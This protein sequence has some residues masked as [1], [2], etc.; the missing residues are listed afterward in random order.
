MVIYYGALPNPIQRGHFTPI[1]TAFVLA[2]VRSSVTRTFTGTLR[3]EQFPHAWD[4]TE[5]GVDAR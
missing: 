5:F 4:A 3:S 2:V 1:E